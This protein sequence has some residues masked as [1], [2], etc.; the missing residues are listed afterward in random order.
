MTSPRYQE[1]APSSIPSLAPVPGATATLIAGSWNGTTGP[2]IGI[3]VDPF[4]AD[5]RLEPGA[6]VA[7][8]VPAAHA[9]FAYVFQGSVDIGG[10]A[11]AVGHLAVLGRGRSLAVAAGGGGAALIVVAGRPIGEPVARYGPFVMNTRAEIV[12]AVE[13]FQNGR[14]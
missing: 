11:V 13:D 6:G 14:F 4:Y 8:P 1:F 7:V 10:T 12:Q 5:L 9:G 3:A 2:V